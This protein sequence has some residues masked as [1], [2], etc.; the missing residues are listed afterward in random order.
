MLVFAYKNRFLDIFHGKQFFQA[1]CTLIRLNT[2][3]VL[4]GL[5]SLLIWVVL[6]RYKFF[7]P[8]NNS[9]V[10]LSYGSHKF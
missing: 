8:T 3:N 1:Y 4:W 5:F 6:A 2:V 10:Q 9:I 7:I